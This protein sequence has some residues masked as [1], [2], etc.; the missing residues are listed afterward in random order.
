MTAA[1]DG[2]VAAEV[3][4]PEIL[5]PQLLDLYEVLLGLATLPASRVL[6]GGQMV[7]LGGQMVLLHALEHGRAPPRVSDD[8]DVPA[9]VRTHRSGLRQIVAALEAEGVTDD[10]IGPTGIRH[11]WLRSGAGL[12]HGRLVVDV[13]APEV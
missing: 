11:R 3:V 6:L 7:L 9:D 5:T 12:G 13:L 4:L 8:G 10:R 1:S 2:P